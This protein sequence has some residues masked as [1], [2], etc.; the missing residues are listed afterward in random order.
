M[1]FLII[2]LD[3]LV[4]FSPPKL[5]GQTIHLHQTTGLVTVRVS[6]SVLTLHVDRAPAGQHHHVGRGAGRPRGFH[7]CAH[8][9]A[10]CRRAGGGGGGARVGVTHDDCRDVF[11]RKV[12][13][14]V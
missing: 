10:R 5:S 1:F 14:C 4:V 12:T 6:F 2:S 13:L 8:E 7:R 9:A 11:K 3:N